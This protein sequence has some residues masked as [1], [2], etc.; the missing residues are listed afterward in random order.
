MSFD[1]HRDVRLFKPNSTVYQHS[2]FSQVCTSIE[3][4]KSTLTPKVYI[5]VHCAS[6]DHSLRE[7]FYQASFTYPL[8]NPLALEDEDS[9]FYY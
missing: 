7:V 4:H 8:A 6:I 1:K 3:Q 5:M 2:D 9:D